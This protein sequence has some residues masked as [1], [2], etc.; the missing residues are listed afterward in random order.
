M[1]IT[2]FPS[3]LSLSLSHDYSFNNHEFTAA[4]NSQIDLNVCFHKKCMQACSI[5][6]LAQSIMNHVLSLQCFLDVSFQ[7]CLQGTKDIM[8][9]FVIIRRK[10]FVILWH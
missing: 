4:I 3:S 1:Y 2:L 7:T 9:Q 5:L 10:Q 8:V 6:L